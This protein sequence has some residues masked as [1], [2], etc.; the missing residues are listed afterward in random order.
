MIAT[1]AAAAR[2]TPPPPSHPLYISRFSLS[3]DP[4]LWRSPSSPYIRE[5][6]RSGSRQ[7]EERERERTGPGAPSLSP[8]RLDVDD[9]RWKRGVKI[10]L[11]LGFP[12]LT[13]G[14]ARSIGR[15][16]KITD[17][18]CFTGSVPEPF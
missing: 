7:G 8:S 14:A 5:E 18:P 11:N 2:L 12:C 6:R 16:R 13:R 17:R 9:R 1:A 4:D 15:P 10:K 3:F